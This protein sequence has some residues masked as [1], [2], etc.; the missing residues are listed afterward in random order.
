M[1]DEINSQISELHK[2]IGLTGQSLSNR[3]GKTTDLGEAEDILREIEEVNFRTM[4]AGRLLFKRTT[5]SLNKNIDDLIEANIKIN[6]EIK[7]LEKTKDVIKT[8]GKFLGKVDSVLDKVKI[9]VA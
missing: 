1:S 4:M 8:V 5:E 3:L 9:L 2:S 6:E 7:T